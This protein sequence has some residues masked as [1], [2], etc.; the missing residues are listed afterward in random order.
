MSFVLRC[1][2]LANI[3]NSFNAMFF[4]ISWPVRFSLF[5]SIYNIIYNFLFPK[6]ISPTF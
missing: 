5:K 6:K 3:S 2:L 1:Q 4:S